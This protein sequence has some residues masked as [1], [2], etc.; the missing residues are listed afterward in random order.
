MFQFLFVG[1]RA[2]LFQLWDVFPL[3]PD[4]PY[5]RIWPGGRTADWF[6]RLS[7][8]LYEWRQHRIH[9]YKAKADIDR[10]FSC[11]LWQKTKMVVVT[12]IAVILRSPIDGWIIVAAD[13]PSPHHDVD[14]AS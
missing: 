1:Q 12:A 4:A 11:C 14:I 7:Q 9:H 5:T 8:Q 13:F 6:I 10:T 3:H 2:Y